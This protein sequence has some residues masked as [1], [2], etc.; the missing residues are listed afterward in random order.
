[1]KHSSDMNLTSFVSRSVADPDPVFGFPKTGSGQIRSFE[2]MRS[3]VSE[4]GSGLFNTGFADPNPVE[5]GPGPQHWYK[6]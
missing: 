4:S 2:V 5:M 3:S 1:M 6:V